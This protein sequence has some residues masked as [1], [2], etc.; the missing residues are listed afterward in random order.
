MEPTAYANKYKIFAVGAI[1]TFMAT[2]DGSI[3]NVAL[4]S[5]ADDLQTSVDIV[6]WVV[7]AYSLTLISLML[8]FGAWTQRRGYD[9]AY[10][11][12]FVFFIL[13][14]T[15]CVFAPEIWSLVAGRIVQATGTAMFAAVGPGMVTTVFP[16]EER[17]KGIGLMVMMVSAGFMIGPPLGGFLL[18]YFTW[19]SIFVINLPI[20][21][22]GIALVYRYFGL[23]KQTR[24]N[25]K[26]H[27]A[28]GLSISAMLVALVL[29]MSLANDYGLK[30]LRVI[31]L[32]V[33]TVVAG[34]LF[35]RFESRPESA[36]IG[37]EI[38]K[39]RQFTMSLAAALVS[40]MSI[41]GVLVLV[42]F[43][44]ER[45]KGLGP[46]QVGLFL[47]ILPI[48][49][50]IF[51]PLTGRLSDKIGYRVLTSLGMILIGASL[52]FFLRLT[53]ASSLQDVVVA[54]VVL[55]AGV[56]MFSTPNSSAVMGAVTEDQRAVASG[57]LATNRNIG[58]SIGVA[59]ATSLFTFFQR[60]LADSAGTMSADSM[61]LESYYPV[62]WVSLGMAAVGLVLCQF[63][64]AR[65]GR[66]AV[67]ESTD[68][69]A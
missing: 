30:D 45:V 16:P 20:G 34:S 15:I 11:F 27:L 51:A 18:K 26:I 33:L 3:V 57:I 32:L 61:F 59:I 47:I 53:E 38:F 1:G 8:I 58:V 67:P 62:M 40:F 37:L 41:S 10:K 39:N 31:G 36:L 12:G 56:G 5:I 69:S 63:R 65:G 43:Y 44:L 68:A 50:F 19:H 14:S 2:L 35:L 42:P 9:F 48:L 64:S 22:I 24:S 21:V 7:L 54:L 55:G 6:A 13:G 29:A 25:R 66:E 4:P 28:G 46:Q 52:G 60:Q 17:G 23:L 49:M